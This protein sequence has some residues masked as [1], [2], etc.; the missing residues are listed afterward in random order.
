MADPATLQRTLVE[1]LALERE[2]V[3]SDYVRRSDAL[4]RAADAVRRLGEVGSPQGILER[5]AEE[6]GTSSEFGRVLI[7]EVREDG[8]HAHALWS[9]EDP[10]AA[11]A[12]LE[13]LRR[14]ADPARVPVDR[15]RGHPPATHRDRGRAR[16]ALASG[17]A[18]DRSAR[19]GG[20]CRH[21]AGRAGQHRGVAARRC[22]SGVRRP[23]ARR[24]RRRGG[25]SLRRGADR[26]V[27][28]GRAARDASAA[29]SRAALGRRV[30]ERAAR[31]NYRGRWR[32]VRGAR[33]A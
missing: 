30:D 26:R 8:L 12:A 29:P 9:A 13:D 4:E 17:A 1:L 3:E 10:D 23:G 19:V 7:G 28:A 5:A 6:L 11:A 33:G 16:G 27:R 31:S 20:V 22:R 18:P 2:I 14:R 32:P 25:R 15:G 21:R 24:A